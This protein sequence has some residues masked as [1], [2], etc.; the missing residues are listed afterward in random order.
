VADGQAYHKLPYFQYYPA[1]F[2]QGTATFT[3]TEV[4]AYQRLLNHQ[5]AHGSVP[6]STRTLAQI[7]RCSP[8]TAKSVWKTIS[9]KFEQGEDG[10]Y[11]NARLEQSRDNS[12]SAWQRQVDRGRASAAAREQ[13][14]FNHGSTT[15][16][17]TVQPQVQPDVNQSESESESERTRKRTPSPSAPGF[18]EFW[19]VYPRKVGKGAAL[20]K[21]RQIKPDSSLTQEIISSI[22]Q[23]AESDQWLKDGGQFIPHP[24]TFLGQQRWLDEVPVAVDSNEAVKAEFMKLVAAR[25]R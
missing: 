4:G 17:T 3:L 25:G 8:S 13:R 14:R 22:R 24:T 9:A 1:D 10:L 12:R 21:W 2:E 20:R 23:H 7:L 5:W 18:D 16:A 15:V 11:R 19:L 6:D